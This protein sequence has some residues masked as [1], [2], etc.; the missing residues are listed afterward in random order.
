MLIIISGLPGTGKTTL[1]KLVARYYR[2]V[3]ISSDAIR[4][5]LFVKP[6]Y[7]KQEKEVVYQ[8]INRLTEEELHKGKNVVVD[9]SFHTG[10]ERKIFKL[11]EKTATRVFV[12]LCTVPEEE[13]KRRLDGRKKGLSDANFDVYLKMKEEF[14]PITEKHLQIGMGTR[15]EIMKKINEFVSSSY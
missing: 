4:K 2:A 7:T 9:A 8:E 1:A 11:A 3:N 10:E 12:I 13:I 6:E 5:K 15:K 14:E